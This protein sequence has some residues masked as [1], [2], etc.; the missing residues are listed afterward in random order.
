[1]CGCVFI[2]V[3]LITNNKNLKQCREENKHPFLISPEIP[4][5]RIFVFKNGFKSCFIKGQ[6][7]QLFRGEKLCSVLCFLTHKKPLQMGIR[8]SEEL[9]KPLK[10]QME[11]TVVV[12]H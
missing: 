11:M 5:L 10:T 9:K 4:W 7:L 6:Q 1:M 12:L 3:F 2:M 8:F